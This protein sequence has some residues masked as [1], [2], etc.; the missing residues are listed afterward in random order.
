MNKGIDKKEGIKYKKQFGDKES[1]H[2]MSGS[3]KKTDNNFF[4]TNGIQF[5]F[6]QEVCLRKTQ[7]EYIAS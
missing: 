7:P 3:R 1:K 5:M 2:E 6:F 4:Q